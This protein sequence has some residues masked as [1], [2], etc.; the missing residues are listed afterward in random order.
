LS[1]DPRETGPGL[2]RVSKLLAR[3]GVCSRRE[4]ER[5]IELGAVVVDGRIVRAQ[6]VKAAP[7]ARIEVTEA[8][9]KAL[10]AAIS[11][12][13]HKPVGVVSINPAEGQ[14]DARALV[15][16]G[17]AHGTA[18]DE[19]D[20]VLAAVDRLA[21]AGRLDRASRGLLL[22]T[23]DG[24]L[25]RALIGG[26]AIPKSYLVTLTA[27]ATQGQIARLNRAMRLDERVLLPMKVKRAGP[28][29]LRFELV[30]GMKHQ[31]RRCCSKVGL[32]VEDLLRDAVGSIRLGDLPEGRW[33][34]LSCREVEGLRAAPGERR[35]GRPVPKK[36]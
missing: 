2:E 13:L 35:R 7:D 27:E 22:L 29:R 24:V 15:T 11:I 34:G 21:V 16:R 36:T 19:V 28:R 30:E 5:L 8:G 4:A 10:G 3:R 33:R 18:E 20:R 25:A 6:G 14:R 26:N 12:A 1:G 9:R 23:S 32:E 17:A 31:I